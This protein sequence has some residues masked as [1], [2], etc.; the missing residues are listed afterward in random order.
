M[1]RSVV[2]KKREKRREERRRGGVKKT[3]EQGEEERLSTSIMPVPPGGINIRVLSG[4]IMD[5]TS[6][7]CYFI[8]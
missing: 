4:V 7:Q 5:P 2:E 1:E 8:Y 6:T 3:V